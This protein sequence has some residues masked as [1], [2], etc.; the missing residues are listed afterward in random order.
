M[1]ELTFMV[2]ENRTRNTNRRLT[3]PSVFNQLLKDIK[4]VRE[5]SR[6]VRDLDFAVLKAQEM[7]NIILFLFPVVIQCLEKD[8]KERRLWLLLSYMIRSCVLPEPEFDDIDKADIASATN[9]FYV[10]FENLF[11]AK[12]CTY[13]VHVLASHLMEI[14]ILGPFTETS[15]FIFENFYG[16]MR[17]SFTPGTISPLKQI[18]Q[19]IYLKRSKT[20]HSC[21]KSIYFSHKDTALE[22][23]SLIYIYSNSTYDMYKI[24]NIEKNNPDILQCNIQ[25]KIEIQFAE[26][27]DL[28]WS[29]VGVFKEGATGQ[30][31]INVPR[32]N[33]HGKVLK[34][35][36]LLLTCPLNVLHEK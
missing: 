8:A 5:F 35:C 9:H 10:L 7:R 13:S 14:C 28:D 17:R 15:A 29:K 25:G 22:R 12:N 18:M 36:S 24:I 1:L 30:E 2:G 6:R 33:V 16:E 3:H 23:N 34:V 26:A 27:Q 21:E 20:Y 32:K 31:I 19:T 11:T 4:F